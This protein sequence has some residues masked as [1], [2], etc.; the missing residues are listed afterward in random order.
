M[1]QD[2]SA[3]S[4]AR[5]ASVLGRL[6]V[7]FAF[8]VPAEAQITG[9]ILDS[10]SGQ[11]ID[12]ARVTVF[13]SVGDSLSLSVAD[14]DGAFAVAWPGGEG[15]YTLRVQALGYEGTSRPITYAGIP[16]VV[17]IRVAPAPVE[18][19]GL[20]VEVEPLSPYLDRFGFYSRR[21]LGTGRFLNVEQ[22]DG[23]RFSRTVDILRRVPG[24][25]VTNGGEPYLR[26]AQGTTFRAADRCFP[27]LVLDDI[28]VRTGRTIESALDEFDLIMPRPG[29]IAAIEVYG[30]SALSPPQW[31]SL[32]NDCGVIVV[33]TTRG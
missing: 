31:R 26:R 23:S 6:V 24:L 17:E 20:A 3:I 12:A 22:M 16:I 1:I 4:P 9:R 32:E 11:G 15:V 29:D 28:I 19:E 2:T 25:R 14:G 33:W 7:L 30:G 10:K 8:A 18:L 13:D 21:R 5:A 27:V